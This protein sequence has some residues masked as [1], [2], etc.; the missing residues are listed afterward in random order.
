MMSRRRAAATGRESLAAGQAPSWD[1]ARRF[2]FFLALLK[3]LQGG[4]LNAVESDSADFKL[5]TQP[6]AAAGI[7]GSL[8]HGDHGTWFELVNHEFRR[9]AGTT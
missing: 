4:N 1:P 7:M 8:R 2:Q 9:R 3:K 5:E 6:A